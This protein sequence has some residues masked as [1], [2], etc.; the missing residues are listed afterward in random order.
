MRKLGIAF[1][2]CVICFLCGIGTFIWE[3]SLFQE[4]VIDINQETEST[5]VYSYVP[6][7]V[8]TISDIPNVSSGTIHVVVDEM[9]EDS[10]LDKD[11]MK[12]IYPSKVELEQYTDPEQTKLDFVQQYEDTGGLAYYLSAW[13]TK[14]LDSYQALNDEIHIRVYYGSNL[15]DKVKIENSYID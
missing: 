6:V 5:L 8:Y 2:I 11:Q 14:R 12:I 7:H 1:A 15:K 3:I 10:S 9:K 13:K 4:N